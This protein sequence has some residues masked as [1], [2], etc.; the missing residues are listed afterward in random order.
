M[1]FVKM[2]EEGLFFGGGGGSQRNCIDR[3]TARPFYV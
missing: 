3:Y 1:G 2:D